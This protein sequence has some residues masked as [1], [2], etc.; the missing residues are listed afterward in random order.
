MNENPESAL[1]AEKKTKAAE[2][3]MGSLLM[4]RQ[5]SDTSLVEEGR[6][7]SSG[8]ASQTTRHHSRQEHDPSFRA[9]RLSD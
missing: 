6:S 7:G 8:K 9:G 5:V 1:E 2:Q 4:A 3:T